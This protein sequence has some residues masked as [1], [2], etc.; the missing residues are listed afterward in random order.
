MFVFFG[1][2]VLVDVGECCDK[3]VCLVVVIVLGYMGL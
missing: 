1:Y 3:V 2:V